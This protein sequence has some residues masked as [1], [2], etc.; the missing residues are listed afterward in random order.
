M[1]RRKR[2]VAKRPFRFIINELEWPNLDVLLPHP[3]QEPY[4]EC[5]KGCPNWKGHL[6]ICAC[7]LPTLEMQR[8]GFS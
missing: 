6:T 8:K 1:K 4:Y 5:C 2:R 7:T 3:I